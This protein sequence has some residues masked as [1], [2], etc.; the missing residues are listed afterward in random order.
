MSILVEPTNGDLGEI[1]F[2][3][4]PTR[5][6]AVAAFKDT[7]H[8]ELLELVFPKDWPEKP[9][10]Q[11]VKIAG[12]VIGTVTFK[13]RVSSVYQVC[14]KRAPKTLSG[15]CECAVAVQEK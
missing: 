15:A 11:E 4:W 10:V 9:C 8:L 3:G 6:D 7:M 5:R 12:T 13:Q 2:V 14:R 1:E